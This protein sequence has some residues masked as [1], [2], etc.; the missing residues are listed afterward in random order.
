MTASAQVIVRNDAAYVIDCGNGVARQL[1]LPMGRIPA[2]DP[3]VT[4]Q[5]WA[6]AARVHFRGL[7]I[8]GKDLIEV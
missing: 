1:V 7:V 8:V 3:E 2:D 6:E 4:D 5:M